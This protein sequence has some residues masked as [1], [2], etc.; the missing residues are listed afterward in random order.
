MITQTHDLNLIPEYG[1]VPVIIH[2][3]QYDT[4]RLLAFNILNGDV[5]FTPAND[6][7]ATID[8][9]KP[10]NHGFEYTLSQKRN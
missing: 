5:V 6:A 4:G 8:G 2:V 9:T 1:S 7:T 10:D 3:S